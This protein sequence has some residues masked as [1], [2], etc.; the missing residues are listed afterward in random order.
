MLKED[1]VNVFGGQT[2]DRRVEARDTRHDDIRPFGFHRHE[3]TVVDRQNP[4]LLEPRPK[5]GGGHNGSLPLRPVD[6]PAAQFRHRVGE[7]DV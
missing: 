5:R 6:L 2:I 7:L 1:G 4:H 3:V